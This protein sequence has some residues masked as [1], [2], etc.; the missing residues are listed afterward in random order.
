MFTPPAT[1]PSTLAQHSRLGQGDPRAVRVHLAA[2]V[3]LRTRHARGRRREL[4]VYVWDLDLN[5]GYV[6]LAQV[7]AGSGRSDVVRGRRGVGAVLIGPAEEMLRGLEEGE[8]G[9]RGCLA[10]R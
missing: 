3:G 6:H 8:L 7:A 1:A 4:A 2:R 9:A 10:D 5:N